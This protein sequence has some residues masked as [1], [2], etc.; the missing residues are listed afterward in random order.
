MLKQDWFKLENIKEN[1][2]ND[3]TQCELNYKTLNFTNQERTKFLSISDVLR[4]SV[5]NTKDLIRQELEIRRALS[6]T[7]LYSSAFEVE[8]QGNC[9][10][11][12]GSGWGHGVGLC[13]IGAAVMGEQCK[14]YD[15]ILLFYYRNAKIQKLYE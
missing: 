3:N 14:T 8:K 11:L 15:E 1:E 13:Q 2:I 6:E 7:H 9:F 5:D 12:H 4:K 10:I